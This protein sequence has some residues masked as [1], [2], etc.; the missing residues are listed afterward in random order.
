MRIAGARAP[1]EGAETLAFTTYQQC[2]R[3]I[4]QHSLRL[5]TLEQIASECHVN[6][7]YL[8]RLFRRYDNQ[9]PY[10]Y[11]LRLKMN[12]RRRTPAT[13]RRA[14]ET[15]GGGGGLRRPVSFLPRVHFR[16]RP[17]AGLLSAYPVTDLRLLIF[18]V[19]EQI[20]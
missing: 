8:C 7:A 5:R 6:N 10:Q 1:L 19:P 2:R 3:H 11:L 9:S 16:F 12:S 4:E 13:T 18:D 17:F 15:G 14:G 20:K